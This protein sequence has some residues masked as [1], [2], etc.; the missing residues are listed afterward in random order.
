[1]SARAA[2]DLAELRQALQRPGARPAHTVYEC[3]DCAERFVGQR[4]CDDC[5]RFCRALGL[6]GACPDCTAIV[7]L[8]ELFDEEVLPS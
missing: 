4:R 7:L 1:M 2:R 5:G 8:T 3:P 6:G